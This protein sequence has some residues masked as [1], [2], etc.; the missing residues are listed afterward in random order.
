[1]VGSTCGQDRTGDCQQRNFGCGAHPGD[2]ADIVITPAGLGSSLSTRGEITDSSLVYTFRDFE[3]KGT[4]RDLFNYIYFQGDTVCFSFCLSK[5]A[6]QGN[7]DAGFINPL[8]G[9][10]YKAE[11]IDVDGNRVSGFS[12]TG[13]IME[14][15]YH[16]RL[17]NPVS[18]DRYCCS[19]ISF[20]VKL[21]VRVNGKSIESRVPGKFRIEYR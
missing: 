11:R 4:V 21:S 16:E 12:L 20:L 1:M 7:I 17:G 8:T 19:D 5:P 18:P 2:D 14:Q 13:S 3:K 10:Y 9:K 6:G 15:F